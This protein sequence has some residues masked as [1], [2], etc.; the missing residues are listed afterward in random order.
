M[1]A[2]NSG[3]RASMMVGGIGGYL[4]SYLA[5]IEGELPEGARPVH[6]GGLLQRLEAGLEHCCS[7]LHAVMPDQ[8]LLAATRVRGISASRT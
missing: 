5:A 1:A 2:S 8:G 7:I 6:C 4:G 3:S